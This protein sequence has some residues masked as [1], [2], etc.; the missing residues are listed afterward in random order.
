[1]TMTA[2]GPEDVLERISEE[3]GASLGLVL[4]GLGVRVGL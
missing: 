4:T 3:L 2:I 1:M